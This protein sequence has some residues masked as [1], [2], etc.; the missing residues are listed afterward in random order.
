MKTILQNARFYFEERDVILSKEFREQL[1]ARLPDEMV[2]QAF[3]NGH[4]FGVSPTTCPPP[5]RGATGFK[6]YQDMFGS[7]S[8]FT[9][10]L[11][12]LTKVHFLNENKQLEKALQG[13]PV[14]CHSHFST[15]CPLTKN[16]I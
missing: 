8:F 1:A 14:C 13:V 6:Q 7:L 5:E 4:H 10:T 3:L 11:Q 16:F 12:D 9:V 15:D 2:P